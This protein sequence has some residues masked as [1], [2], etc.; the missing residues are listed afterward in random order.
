MGENPLDENEDGFTLLHF[1]S[2]HGR[3]DILKYLVEDEK[4]VPPPT[5]LHIAA[6]GEQFHVVRYLVEECQLDPTALDSFNRSPLCYACMNGEIEMARYLVACMSECMKMDDIMF[7]SEVLSGIIYDAPQM[8]NSLSCACLGGHLS[9]VKFLIEECKCNP[10][11]VYNGLAPLHIAAAKGFLS[12]VK[13]LL[14]QGCDP[15]IKCFH[16]IQPIHMAAS[17]GQLNVLKYFIEEQA[18]NP[19]V[20]D[21]DGVTPLHLAANAGHLS[22]IRYLVLENKCDPLKECREFSTSLHCAAYSGHI[23]IIRFFVKELGYDSN[24]DGFNSAPIHSAAESGE[25]EMVKVLVD[26]LGCDPI[27]PN[28]VQQTAL[29]IAV[30]EGHLPV[31][32]YLIEDKKCITNDDKNTILH[33]SASFGHLHILKYLINEQNMDKNS[34]GCFYN[35]LSLAALSGHLSVVTYLLEIDSECLDRDRMTPLH[36]ASIEG[37]LEIVKY[38]L[39]SYP[40]MFSLNKASPLYLAISKGKLEIVKYMLETNHNIILPDLKS[41][42]HTAATSGKLEITQYL[43]RDMKCDPTLKDNSLNT[44]LHYACL[45]QD[46]MDSVDKFILHLRDTGSTEHFKY[47]PPREEFLKVVEYLV[48]ELKCDVNSKNNQDITPLH[49]AA[50]EGHLEIVRYLV[51]KKAEIVCYDTSGNTPLHLAARKNHLD[52]VK[53]LTG[54]VKNYPFKENNLQQTPLHVALESQSFISALYLVVTMFN[55]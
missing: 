42:L 47:N 23:D 40:S 44:P 36:Y 7:H 50:K 27:R 13:Y 33:D 3:L 11:L 1:A 53:F 51:E 49:N 24:C 52:V 25:L 12:I 14:S 48:G 19:S 10:N 35:P 32:K 16:D 9:A 4:C 55:L 31:L 8:D 45:G 34:Y 54:K 2:M 38:L 37:H 30:V 43:I 26:E 21:R 41:L 28:T 20:Q 17:L 29:Q 39:S 22:V 18:Y 6:E 46:I 5:T 15:G